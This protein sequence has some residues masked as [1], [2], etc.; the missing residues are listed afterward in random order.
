MVQVPS[1]AQAPQA[2]PVVQATHIRES[3]FIMLEK[4]DGTRSKFCGF[5]QQ[6]NLFLRL[7]PSQYLDDSMQVAFIGSLLSGNAFSWFAPFLEKYS[8]VL[9]DMTQFEALFTAVFGDC[10]RKRVA[11][12]KMQSLRQG[13]RSS[14]IYAIKFQQLTCD[15]E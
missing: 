11:E 4:F 3:K 13:T 14:A 2:L 9:Q 12:T 15:L 5:V 6:V 7:H 1:M 10:D 8:P